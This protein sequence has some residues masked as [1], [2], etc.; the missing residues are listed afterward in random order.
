MKKTLSLLMCILFFSSCS[1]SKNINNIKRSEYFLGTLI[2]LT[3][4][5]YGLSEKTVIDDC[6]SLVSEYEH[7]FSYYD[8]TSE[9]YHINQNA[10]QHPVEVSNI[11]FDLISRSLEYC[12]LTNGAFDIGLG[13]IIALWDEASTQ[14][15]PPDKEDISLFAGF[16][17]YEH[18]I[19]D[20]LNKTIYFDDERVSIHLGA[21]AKGYVQDIIVN[22]LKDKGVKS[23]LLDFGGSIYAIGCKN[24]KPFSIGITDPLSNGDIIGTVDISDMAVVTSGNYRRFFEYDGVIFHHIID[25]R[26]AFPSDNGIN[27]VSVFSDSAFM[28]D[29]LSTA[30]F[31]LGPEE[32]VVL[33]SSENTGYVIVTDDSVKVNGVILRK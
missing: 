7:L 1:A 29:C 11:M 2:S 18:I 8:H 32:A 26:T 20:N 24:E 21:C 30:A 4:F 25:S 9:L 13:K 17:G 10:N 3:V 22:F 27:S 6:F 16:K 28:G 14:E 5:D 23:A 15:L 19:I 31:V 12:E 33:L